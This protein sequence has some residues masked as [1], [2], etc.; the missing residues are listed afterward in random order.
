MYDLLLVLDF[1][2]A[3][4]VNHELISEPISALTTILDTRFGYLCLFFE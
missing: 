1:A 2:I 3:Y 4:V